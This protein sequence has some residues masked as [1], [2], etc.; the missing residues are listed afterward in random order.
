MPLDLSKSNFV[1]DDIFSKPNRLMQQSSHGN[2]HELIYNETVIELNSSTGTMPEVDDGIV[3]L[4]ACVA[5]LN[6]SCCSRRQAINVQKCY[7]GYYVYD[8][9]STPPCT[10]ICL[11]K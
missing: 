3:T 5:S 11:S 4:H 8:T 10:T 9:G 2:I 6:L 1:I 7:G